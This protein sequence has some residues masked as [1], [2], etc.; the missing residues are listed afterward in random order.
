VKGS[1]IM[2][3]TISAMGIVWYREEDYL[4]I[5]KIMSDAH[6]LPDTYADWK[7]IAETTERQ[8]QSRG[9]LVV[10]AVI[11]LDEFP[12]WCRTRGLKLDAMARNQ[13]AS[14]VAMLKVKAN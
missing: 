14:Y 6:V 11:D 3:P 7:R 9:V 1:E 13:Y 10:R 2:T 4:R 12:A 8:M 5:L